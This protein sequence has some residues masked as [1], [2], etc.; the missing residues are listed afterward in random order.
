MSSS[1]KPIGFA[2]ALLLCGV[3]VTACHAPAGSAQAI[4]N[5]NDSPTA[6]AVT[7]P[8]AYLYVANSPIA[9][10]GSGSVTAYGPGKSGALRT[11]LAGIDGPLALR[12]DSAG[13]LYVANGNFAKQTPGSVSIF[14]AGSTALLRNLPGPRSTYASALALDDLGGLYVASTGYGLASGSVAIY[15]PGGS[16]ARS[17]VDGISFPT[18][19]GFRSET[20]YVGN[21]NRAA[22]SF[23]ND[24][25]LG[26]SSP[27]HTIGTGAPTAIAFDAANNVYVAAT[28]HHGAGR[29]IE[30]YSPDLSK[31]VRAI[32]DGGF[33]TALAFDPRGN[34]Y[35]AQDGSVNVYAAQ[36]TQLIRTITQGVSMPSSLVFDGAGDLYVANSGNNSVTVYAPDRSTVMRTIKRGIHAPTSLAMGRQ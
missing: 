29:D 26:G 21:S 4:P 2:L 28:L 10:G 18:A 32:P 8:L 33:A 25:A 19:L 5:Q 3:S 17:I 22:S 1:Y 12:I 9:R 24:Y 11:Y 27:L 14:A 20:L 34:L 35:V 36:G 31:L 15:P 23:L 7:A 13:Q 16:T 30:V 6:S